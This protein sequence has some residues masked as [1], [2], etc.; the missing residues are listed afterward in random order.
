M[1]CFSSKLRFRTLALA[2]TL[3]MLCV[4]STT[5]FAE[6]SLGWPEFRGPYGTGHAADSESYPTRW[7]ETENVRWKTPIQF[8]GWSTPVVL[9]GEVWLTTA[10]ETGHDFYAI[11]IDAE[12]GSI[13]YSKRLFHSDNPEPLGNNV[14]GYASPSPAIEK[15]RVYVNFGS[16]GT[17]C[18]DTDSRETVWR[19]EDLECRHFRGPGSSAILYEDLLILTF[20]GVD[21]QYLVALDKE[22]GKTRWRSDRSTV[23]N[24][25][26]EN[27]LPKREGDF[28]KAYSTPL[29]VEV[30][31]NPLMISVGSFVAFGH[32]PRTGEERWKITSDGFSASA[33][34]VVVNDLAYV[35]TGYGTT[36][37]R[38]IRYDGDGDVSDTHIA[39]RVGGKD[40]PET[41]SPIAVGNRVY[42]VSD[43]G[44]ATCFD[45][46]TGG[47]LWSERLGGNYIGSPIY[48]GGHL[49]FPN[50][51]GKTTVIKPGDTFDLVTEN[52]LDIGMM[53][54]P[55]A[56]DG[57]L[58]LRTKTHLYRID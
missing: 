44:A 19:R 14:N 48:V 1:T 27:G 54:S 4:L 20:D 46:K 53:A 11:G 40:V 37:L 41:T 33:R 15:G 52:E 7:S 58:Y 29:I 8:T 31:N 26:D 49:Y 17:A 43:R 35:M 28:R 57:S 13:F 42:T 34:P 12:T 56:A 47:V 9:D 16:Y 51:Q 24:D 10:L 45:A 30:D 6:T 2:A 55:A 22:T 23:W 21:Q 3:V 18:I 5:S 38:A 32:D 25:L 50:V 39:W 36:E